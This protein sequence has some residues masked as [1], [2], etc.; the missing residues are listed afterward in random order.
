MAVE[1]SLRILDVDVID[2]IRE[3]GNKCSRVEE[4]MRKVTRIEIDAEPR[5]PSDCFESLS[6]CDEV[7]GDLRWMNLEA[8]AHALVIE[9]VNDWVPA[10]REVGVTPLDLS[11]IVGRKRI[12]LVPDR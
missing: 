9:D 8:E 4:L 2:A 3:L 1:P 5:T 10:L 11:K 12:Q 7:V 6:S